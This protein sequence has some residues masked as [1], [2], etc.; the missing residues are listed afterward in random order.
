MSTCIISG[1]LL[2][3]SETPISGATIRFNIET[4]VLNGAS[5]LLGPKNVATTT[6]VDGSWSITAS[7]NCSGVL[8]IDCP[9]D[10]AN[11]T[12]KYT[13]SIIVPAT[14]TAQFSNVWADSQNVASATY[15]L[16]FSII[17]GTALRS[18][19]APGTPYQVITNDVNGNL[20]GVSPGISGNVLTSDGTQWQSTVAASGGM[21]QLTGD[22]TA[23]PGAGS[24]AATVV[25]V[26]GSTASLVHSAELLA[27]AATNSNTSS[28]V[29]K[30]DGSG[31]FSAGTITASLTGHA[32]LDVATSSLGNLTDA[33]TDGIIVTGGSG[34]T[35]GTVSLAQHVADTTH[36]GYLSSTDWNT[37][38]GKG[39]GTVTSVS[40]ASSNGFTGSSSGGSTPS[41]TLATSITGVLQGNG[42][43]IS[44]ATTT[45]S[46][47]VVLATGPTLSSPIVG[48]QSQGDNSTKGASTS[49]VDTAVANAVAGVNPAVAVQ[50]AT[51]A[52]GD[53]SGFT[54][55]NGV[56][57]VG[58]TFTGTANTAITIDGF[59]FTAL[60]QR[61]LVKNDTQSPSGAF[62]GVYYV[63]QVQTSLLAPILTRALDYDQPSDMNNTGAIPVING[64]VNG[65]SQWVLT[66]LV[67]TVG[68]T[69]LTYAVF[70]K[71]PASYLLVANNLSDVSSRS[72]S[73]NNLVGSTV[74][75]GTVTT[76]AAVTWSSGS[77]F[78]VTLTSGNTCAVTFSGAASGQTI[79][80]QVTNGGSG[81]TGVV[82]WPTVKWA[83]GA[84]PTMST[85]TAALDVYTFIY[86]GSYYVGS[87]VQNLS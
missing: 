71:N 44:A 74:A 47:N 40:V 7:Q 28:T 9:P 50:A 77:V 22:V 30:R 51:T 1:I 61:L 81:G 23:G 72:T 70:S 32:S 14:P 87:A 57:G 37:F 35:V 3:P 58:A 2:D 59:T 56:S 6:A 18:Q 48:T 8:T 64:T 16:T 29:V 78:T 43:A 15:P 36:N 65:T 24:Q 49:Y 4:P 69:P 10:S 85:G 52:A 63:T 5:S 55:N 42:T 39:S 12:V 66:S 20:S 62:N 27:N 80:V 82:T 13:F 75:I 26:G 31:N 60:G 17:Q 53:T 73:L 84:Q 45:G 86:N 19:I 54:Y 21:T 11:S 76:A 38:N 46:G 41:I 67:V 34:A 79:V 33:G 83:G 68:T 25:Q